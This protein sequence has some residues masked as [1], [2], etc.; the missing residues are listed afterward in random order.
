R[1]IGFEI[2]QHITQMILVSFISAIIAFLPI[3]FFGIFWIIGSIITGIVET[4]HLIGFAGL[5]LG[6]LLNYLIGK[7]LAR[8]SLIDG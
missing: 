6:I 5:W 2:G 3:G 4:A 8:Y 1:L 7:I